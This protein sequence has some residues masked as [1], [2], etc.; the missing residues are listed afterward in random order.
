MRCSCGECRIC[1]WYTGIVSI[2]ADVLGV[3]VVRWMRGLVECVRCVCVWLGTACEEKGGGQWMKGLGL[4]FYNPV[5][6]LDV[7]LCLG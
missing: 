4:G 2:A 3:G 1:G 5:G 7:C 6:V